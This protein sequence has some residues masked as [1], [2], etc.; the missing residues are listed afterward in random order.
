LAAQP[1]DLL[2]LE[3]PENDL[4][5][6]AQSMLG[7][8]MARVASEGVQVIVETHSD[9]IINGICLAIHKGQIKHELTK[10]YY[11]NRKD[12]DSASK[13]YNIEVKPNGRID[14]RVLKDNGI[15]GFFDQS[16]KDLKQILF[17]PSKQ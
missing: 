7:Q 11:F 8:L 6:Q 4:H 10:L 14:D 15:H 2:I 9:H 13:V 16:N 3:N 12:F 5:P 1:G 17:T